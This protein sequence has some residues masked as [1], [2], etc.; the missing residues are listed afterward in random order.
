MKAPQQNKNVHSQVQL[1]YDSTKIEMTNFKEFTEEKANSE[2]P[3]LQDMTQLS[4]VQHNLTAQKPSTPFSD[5][6]DDSTAFE[7]PKTSAKKRTKGEEDSSSEYMVEE[8][9][10][11]SDLEEK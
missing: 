8:D 6:H 2:Y 11:N 9:S 7:G 3:V 5:N 4:E 1:P 10:E